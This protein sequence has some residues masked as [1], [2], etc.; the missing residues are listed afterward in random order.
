MTIRRTTQWLQKGDTRRQVALP[1]QETR[2]R[3]VE[4]RRVDRMRKTRFSVQ[5]HVLREGI[6]VI[7]RVS[8]ERAGGITAVSGRPARRNEP[9]RPRR[10]PWVKGASKVSTPKLFPPKYQCAVWPD[11]NGTTTTREDGQLSWEFR[12]AA[13]LE[14]GVWTQVHATRESHRKTQRGW[15]QQSPKNDA[16]PLSGLPAHAKRV[17]W[18]RSQSK[19]MVAAALECPCGEKHSARRTKVCE[20]STP[21]AHGALETNIQHEKTNHKKPRG[22]F[23]CIPNTARLTL[24]I[25]QEGER[26]TPSRKRDKASMHPFAAAKHGAF[27]DVG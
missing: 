6:I 19:S 22:T 7:P 23:F 25:E 15:I 1:Y 17:S 20:E 8:V 13:L 12:T 18:Q 16:D 4:A 5:L 14:P 27:E 10:H 21:R 26:P 24:R 11:H 9:H 3:R 2:R